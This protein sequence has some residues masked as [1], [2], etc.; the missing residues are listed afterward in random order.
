VSLKIYSS[1]AAKQA[2]Y[3]E[4]KIVAGKD[5]HHRKCSLADV[6]AFVKE[7]HYSHTIPAACDYVFRLDYYG[8]LAGACVFGAVIGNAGS[9][10]PGIRPDE[11]R[12]LV[13][14]VLLDEVPRNSE[15]RFI[16]WCLR[17]LRRYTKL[18]LIISFADPEHGHTGTV[19]KASN[20]TYDGL[21]KPQRARMI[22]DEIERHPR[23][24]HR[25]HG[26]SSV[27]KLRTNHDVQL[28]DR[29]SKHRYLYFIDRSAQLGNKWLSTAI[30]HGGR[31]YIVLTNNSA[32]FYFR[33][34]NGMLHKLNR[35]PAKLRISNNA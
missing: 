10:Y 15:S 4:R 8:K 26:T 19:Y 28:R 2:A 29:E 11:Q 30:E 24:L 27:P 3:R 13:R 16:G 31:W 18:R 1:N 21:Q 9:R 5:L 17:W 23:S 14:L 32:H 12:E 22:V 33:I 34:E 7:H 35:V 20:W 25:T 6:Q